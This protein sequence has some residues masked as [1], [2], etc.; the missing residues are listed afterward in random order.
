[1]RFI[2]CLGF[3]R[4]GDFIWA[5]ADMQA[6]GFLI[7]ATSGRTTLA[8]EGLQHLD[9]HSHLAAATVPNCLSYDPSFAYELAVIVWHGMQRMY[10]KGDGVFYYLTTMNENYLHPALPKNIKEIETKITK[11]L[12]Q[13]PRQQGPKAHSKKVRLLGSGT[14]L[15]EAITA[16]AILADEFGINAEVWSAPSF[17]E[18]TREAQQIRHHNHLDPTIKPKRAY[19]EECLNDEDSPI[20]AATDYV[21]Q[22]PE[23]LAPF[24]SAPYYCLGTDGFGRSDSRANLRR[25]YGIDS[26]HIAYYAVMALYRQGKINQVTLKRAA[27]KLKIDKKAAYPL[28]Q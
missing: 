18:L 13:L 11:G 2:P 8:G 4:V 26:N 23:Q 7:G 28:Y 19:V 22:Y 5:A 12:Y 17:N 21:R 20:V 14:I 27:R 1:M 10:A 6:R 9:G 24:V 3:Q 15:L 16:A 25:F